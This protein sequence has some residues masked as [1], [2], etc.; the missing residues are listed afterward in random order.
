MISSFLSQ[1]TQI[2]RG[3]NGSIYFVVMLILVGLF[4]LKILPK[5]IW[6]ALMSGLVFL[7]FKMFEKK[8]V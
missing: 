6:L 3:K 7:I 1:A 2:L 5:I 8:T 4:I